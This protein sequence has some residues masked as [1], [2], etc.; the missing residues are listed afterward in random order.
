MPD[1]CLVLVVDDDAGV[2]GLLASW[3]EHSVTGAAIQV[4]P[5]GD[6]AAALRLARAVRPVL[7]LTDKV[8]PGMDG[9]ELCR[10][11]STDPATQGVPVV[12]ISGELCAD[13][14]LAAGAVAC[15]TKPVSLAVL[16]DAI[17]PYLNQIPV[18]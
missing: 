7:V 8:M 14:A 1:A 2:R 13:E 3:L 9:L 17:R 15:L 11:L 18:R 5:V 12:L 10:Q 6:A 16:A 4:R